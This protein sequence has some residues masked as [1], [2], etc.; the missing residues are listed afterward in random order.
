MNCMKCGVEIE[1]GQVFCQDCL[2]EMAN[3]PVKPGT[4]VQLPRTQE[5]LPSK[6]PV[7]RRAP[8]AEEQVKSLKKLLRVLTVGWL[9]T[10]ALLAALVYPAIA[11]LMEDDFLP[12]QNYSSVTGTKSNVSRET[13][14]DTE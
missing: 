8:S 14:A 2:A 3:Y 9:I 11:H 1:A 4:A 7:H 5:G 10:L 12:G 13:F 6:K